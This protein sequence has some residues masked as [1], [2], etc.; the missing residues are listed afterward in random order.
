MAASNFHGG[1]SAKCTGEV[2]AGTEKRRMGKAHWE[3]RMAPR[4]RKKAM[5]KSAFF[6]KKINVDFE[7]RQKTYVF[8]IC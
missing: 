2:K 5:E 8:N 1:Q 3:V 7:L 6:P 4:G